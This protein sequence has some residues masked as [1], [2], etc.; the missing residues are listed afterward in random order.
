MIDS[1][2][3]VIG[4][5]FKE[6]RPDVRNTKV[7]DLVYLLKGYNTVVDAYDIWVDIDEAK[8]EHEIN[9]LA[10]VLSK[11]QYSVFSIQ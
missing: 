4:L 11:N 10:N 1:K 8:I 9:C 3:L 5:T 7:A 2:I 6:S